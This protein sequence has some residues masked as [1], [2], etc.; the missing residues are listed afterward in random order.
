MKAERRGERREENKE[1]KRK[2]RDN[3]SAISLMKSP[4][5]TMK[6]RCTIRSVRSSL[7]KKSKQ[8]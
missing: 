2:K 8:E 6:A 7:W 3:S 4:Q 5:L 1:K